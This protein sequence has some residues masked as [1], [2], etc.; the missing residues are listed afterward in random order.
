MLSCFSVPHDKPHQRYY[1]ANTT[2]GVSDTLGK[3]KPLGGNANVG[4]AYERHEQCG[5]EGDVEVFSLAYQV[6]GDCP[7]GEDGERLVAPREVAPNNFEP[8]GIAQTIN[9][10]SNGYQEEGDANEQTLADEA[11]IKVEEVGGY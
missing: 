5:E 10:H 3:R 7:K 8:L 9:E 1:R 11:L 6:N 4:G 2:K